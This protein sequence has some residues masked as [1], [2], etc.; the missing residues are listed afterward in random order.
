MADL[1]RDFAL[2]PTPQNLKILE[3]LISSGQTV[4]EGAFKTAERALSFFGEKFEGFALYML[5]NGLRAVPANMEAL[6]GYAENGTALAAQLSALAGEITEMP[7]S[8]LKTELLHILGAKAEEPGAPTTPAEPAEPQSPETPISREPARLTAEAS[9]AEGAAKEGPRAGEAA[10]EAV[11]AEG[12]ETGPAETVS[13]SEPKPD[14][15]RNK[16]VGIT[17]SA[18]GPS[19]PPAGEITPETARG[20]LKKGALTPS[21]SADVFLSEESE[22]KTEIL[23]EKLRETARKADGG[24]AER[25]AGEPLSREAAE[26]AARTRVVEKFLLKPSGLTKEKFAE[27]ARELAGAVKRAEEAIAKAPPESRPARVSEALSA[28]KENLAFQARQENA[29][30]L[31]IPLIIGGEPKNAELYVWGGG[32]GG[33][34]GGK[35]GRSALVALDTANLGRV[36]TYITKYG[37]VVNFQFR[38]ESGEVTELARTNMNALINAAGLLGLRVGDVL[39]RRLEE[40]FSIV[41]EEPAEAARGKGGA[42]LGFDRRA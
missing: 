27:N 25:D 34:K 30:F 7:E 2:K 12:E 8:S 16:A 32:K 38:L 24:R 10:K 3:F 13:V 39:Y 26:S 22:E 1:L 21:K 29:V 37:D 33:S 36:E 40:P 4:S 11:S 9:R 18:V 15:A 35:T 17:E 28:L 6:R 31:Q 20:A 41:S 5:N 23:T 42:K 14:P 19:R